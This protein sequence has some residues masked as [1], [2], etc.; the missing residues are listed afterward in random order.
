MQRLVLILRDGAARLLRMGPSRRAH[1]RSRLR[2]V[3]GMRAPQMRTV[4]ATTDR[5]RGRRRVRKKV[6][7]HRIWRR[8]ARR[9]HHRERPISA[10]LL[11]FLKSLA[12]V[13]DL[14]A[15]IADEP[16]GHTLYIEGPYLLSEI[17]PD[18][19]ARLKTGASREACIP[20]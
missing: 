12:S 1:A 19:H 10:D 15:L 18:R 6:R 7:T 17:E 3:F 4:A 13:P 11:S 16:L 5:A 20:L 2:N 8:A 14:G 9:R